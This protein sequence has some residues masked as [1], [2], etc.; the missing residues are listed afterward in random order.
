ME[1]CAIFNPQHIG[2]RTRAMSSEMWNE[3]FL[4]QYEKY[5]LT[6]LQFSF[7]VFLV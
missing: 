5:Y 2:R 1:C 6:S 3:L 4:I 7:S